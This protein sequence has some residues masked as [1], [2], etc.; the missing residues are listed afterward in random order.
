V[1]RGAAQSGRRQ[2]DGMLDHRACADRRAASHNK[3]DRKQESLSERDY[4][5]R[6]KNFVALCKSILI[7][8]FKMIN[9]DSAITLMQS[10]FVMS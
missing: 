9:G 7:K 6:P 8:Y 3:V 4:L 1:R 5:R 10:N 2:E